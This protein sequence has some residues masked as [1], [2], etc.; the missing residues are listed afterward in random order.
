MKASTASF[1]I[2]IISLI[3][4]LLSGIHGQEGTSLHAAG[5]VDIYNNIHAVGQE[6]PIQQTGF[7]STQIPNKVKIAIR[8][9]ALQC[10][11]HWFVA[12]ELSFSYPFPTIFCNRSYGLQA[13]VQERN[14]VYTVPRLR[15][16]PVLPLA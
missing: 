2:F 5:K 8:I 12:S 1:R 14:G 10:D 16:P 6:W 11:C 15:G 7:K 4:L 3:A 9:K 13:C